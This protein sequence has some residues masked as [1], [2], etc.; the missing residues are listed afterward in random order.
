MVCAVNNMDHPHP[1]REGKQI[2]GKVVYLQPKAE[3]WRED[4]A[5]VHIV[6]S[7]WLD[8]LHALLCATTV[9]DATRL[10]AALGVLS[11]V[12]KLRELVAAG[13]TVMV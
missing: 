6:T 11:H 13:S 8:P 5:G 7:D 3:R 12:L 9:D 2:R 4:H 10:R 1:H